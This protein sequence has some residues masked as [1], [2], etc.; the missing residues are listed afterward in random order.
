MSA[1]VEVDVGAN[2]AAKVLAGGNVSVN[3]DKYA[4][5]AYRTAICEGSGQGGR[6]E[7]GVRHM[8]ALVAMHFLKSNTEKGL[9]PAIQPFHF[10]CQ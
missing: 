6:L 10:Y 4:R 7:K 2:I 3:K 9:H 1:V 8:S 5:V